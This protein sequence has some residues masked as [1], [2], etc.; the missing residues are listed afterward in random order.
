MQVYSSDEHLYVTI[1]CLY[2]YP[3]VYHVQ[4]VTAR[5]QLNNK[6]NTKIYNAHM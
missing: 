2:N 4:T 5:I 1:L 6:N 3:L